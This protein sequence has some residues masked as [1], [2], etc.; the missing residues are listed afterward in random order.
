MLLNSF[1]I[2]LA[3]ISDAYPLALSCATSKA[4]PKQRAK[5][6]AAPTSP[7]PSVPAAVAPAAPE[8]ETVGVAAVKQEAS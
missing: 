4:P 5:A 2:L 8:A 7:K 1:P 3:T 6:K